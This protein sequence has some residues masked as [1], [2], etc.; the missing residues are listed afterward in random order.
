MSSI[1]PSFSIAWRRLRRA[2]VQSLAGAATLALGL[3]AAAAIAD[4]GWRS[5]AGPLPYAG[6]ERLLFLWSEL[7]SSGY[8]HA[9]FSGPEL[10]DLADRSTHIE[11]LGA[12]WPTTGALVADAAGREPR[13]VAVGLA[14]PDLFTVL[15]TS[16]LLGRSLLP[17][18][19]AVG[20]PP[21]ALLSGELWRSYF[22]G[23]STV[24]G[25]TVR[26][27]GGWG[28]GGGTFT[29]VGILP[30]SFRL[31][32]PAHAGVPS[33]LDVWI[34]FTGD[35]RDF[36]RRTY[37]LRVVGRLAPG[38]DFERA[39]AEV[40]EIGAAVAAEH[41]EYAGAGR[42]FRAAPLRRELAQ[43]GRPL[44][45]AL[46]SGA[47]LLLLL[48]CADV[49]HL[50][51]ARAA[52]RR[53]ELAIR[54]AQGA[55][56]R[57]VRGELVVEA[58]L[59]SI[60]GALGGVAVAAACLRALPALLPYPVPELASRSLSTAS[61]FG[62]CAI[63]LAVALVVGLGAGGAIP[64][65]PLGEALRGGA[66]AGR[67]RTERRRRDAL[68]LGQ[69]AAGT[70]LLVGAGLF[71]RTFYE[72]RRVDHG[73][74]EQSVLT[75]QLTLPG[76]RYGSTAAI[77]GLAREL[78]RRLGRLPGV[79]AVGAINQ[80]PLDRL[81]NWS[82]AYTARG[83]D[84]ARAGRREAD[85]RLVSPGYFDAVGAR[86]VAGR[87]FD[88]ADDERGAPVAI[89]DELL[90]ARAFPGRSPLGEEIQVSA[91]RRD[92]FVPAWARV[93]GVVAH[94]RHHDLAQEVRE[95]VWLPLLQSSRNQL[96]VVVRTS[97]DPGSLVAPVREELRAIDPDLAA[98]RFQPL[99]DYVDRA[100]AGQRMAM[101][102][103]GAFALVALLLA[104]VGIYGVLSQA[105][106]ERTR[107]IGVRMALGAR[108][109]AVVRLIGAQGAR[110]VVAGLL[111]GGGGS[112]ALARALRTL[113]YGVAP[114][115]PATYA[116]SAVLVVTVAA[117]ALGL[118]ARRAARVDP[119][120]ALRHT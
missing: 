89:V 5:L 95:Q 101:L 55:S 87:F 94:L 27:D 18:D 54:L 58:M 25:R 3:G 91:W 93:V 37:F 13:A 107:E 9:P 63:A 72:L 115:D 36:G 42:A 31:L 34:P 70:M 1:A 118:P 40:A 83:E 53:A 6:A 60:L 4:L 90:A 67:S 48:C 16:P 75:L 45:L 81:P 26:I 99:A 69:V 119:L 92:S 84:E 22:G 57:R 73:F 103:A 106:S 120:V 102:L 51:L 71:T 110:P 79:E 28:F 17:R 35:P 109:S 43:S 78:E 49:A 100:T 56:R 15:G 97:G 19:G 8:T 10:G 52:P 85:A 82:T 80:L 12:V 30:P 62:L 2:P 32:L 61:L 66:A 74:Q 33:A 46:L 65:G 64:R 111:L 76:S 7:Q 96:A 59:V 14:T 39:E 88:D 29:V 117:T 11:A 77:A 41:A 113:L 44:L 108:P 104:A 114:N 116:A 24:L 112:L 38:A 98:S 23:D 50:E 21:V 47:G 68:V 20:A 105:V 86:L